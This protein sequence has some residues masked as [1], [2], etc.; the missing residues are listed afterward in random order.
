MPAVFREGKSPSV[1]VGR[2]DTG[3]WEGGLEAHPDSI[4]IYTLLVVN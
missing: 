1:C 2:N 4:T 3:S